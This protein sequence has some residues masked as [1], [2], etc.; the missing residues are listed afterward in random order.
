MSAQ[1]RLLALVQGTG[2]AA[3]GEL[4][5]LYDRLAP[6][7]PTFMLGTWQGG[8]FERADAMA[9]MLIKMRWYGKRFAGIE[10]VEP[11]LCR[12]DAGEIYSFTGMGMA[13]L[14]EMSYRGTVSA[15]MIYDDQPIIDHFR[16]VSHDVV[17]GAMDAKAQESV[18]YFHLTRVEEA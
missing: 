9:A 7:S 1:D 12:D 6:V 2:S 15:A 8:V 11:L 18:L 5:R 13:R 10:N 14:R 17:I 3:P 4:E 16:R